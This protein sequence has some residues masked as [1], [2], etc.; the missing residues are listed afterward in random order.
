[1]EQTSRFYGW[2]NRLMESFRYA[3]G[4]HTLDEVAAKYQLSREAVRRVLAIREQNRLRY[5]LNV[6]GLEAEFW[7]R[8]VFYD[9]YDD[10]PSSDQKIVVLNFRS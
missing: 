6:N 1:M 5:K 8:E 10:R 9:G 2:R 4:G 7:Q 3:H